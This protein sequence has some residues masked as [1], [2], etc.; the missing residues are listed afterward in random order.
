MLNKV[1]S[2]PT[3][4]KQ[5]STNPVYCLPVLKTHIPS[6]SVA[7]KTVLTCLRGLSCLDSLMSGSVSH[8]NRHPNGTV[9]KKNHSSIGKPNNR[10]SSVYASL[11]HQCESVTSTSHITYGIMTNTVVS[12]FTRHCEMCL[13][14]RLNWHTTGPAITMRLNKR[15]SNFIVLIVVSYQLSVTL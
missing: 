4:P 14:W 8:T 1:S 2:S 10:K 11:N 9:I 13:I 5:Q 3:I 12:N 6:G 7:Y 15:Y